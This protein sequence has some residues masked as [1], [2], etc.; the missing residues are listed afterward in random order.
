MITV[1]IFLVSDR[2]M[3]VGLGKDTATSLGV[4]FQA[5]LLLG[6]GL[7]ALAVG[8]VTAV[9]GQ[10]PFLGL[11][12]PNLVSLWRGDDLRSN[13]PYVCLL[14]MILITTCDLISR[15]LVAP[16]EMPVS[17]IL[18]TLGGAVFLLL[19]WQQAKGG[20]KQGD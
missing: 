20:G 16:L 8:I 10:L 2:L 1:I 11:I 12:V 14:G 3:V 4:N 7:V 13:L 15:T 17:L 18:G 9:I 19:L 6:V 5:V